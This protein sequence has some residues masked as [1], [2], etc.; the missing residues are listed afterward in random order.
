[1]FVTTMNEKGSYKFE[2]S[3]KHIWEGLEEKKRKGEMI[4]Y[5]VISKM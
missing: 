2:R 1:M 3:K 4:N 5:I